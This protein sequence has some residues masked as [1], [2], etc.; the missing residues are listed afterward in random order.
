[1]PTKEMKLNRSGRRKSDPKLLSK[2][3][4]KVYVTDDELE[5]ISSEYEASGNRSR[6]D[7]LRKKILNNKS[8]IVNPIEL[9]KQLDK[10]GAEISRIGNNI[11]QITRYANI[12]SLRGDIDTYPIKKFNSLMD[13]YM[14]LR[15]ELVKAYRALVRKV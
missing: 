6:S 8:S 4:L 13:E 12:L 7:F 1:M 5:Q 2:N 15:R 9:V 3:L 10:I 11:N 14:G